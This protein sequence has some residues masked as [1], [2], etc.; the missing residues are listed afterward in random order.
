MSGCPLPLPEMA[1]PG[2]VRCTTPFSMPTST[3]T[4]HI[5]SGVPVSFILTP[6]YRPWVSAMVGSAAKD[7]REA[8]EGTRNLQA[9]AKNTQTPCSLDRFWGPW[10]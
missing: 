6:R 1:E 7:P 10:I 2:R 5:L 4:S 3:Q 8:E 9:I